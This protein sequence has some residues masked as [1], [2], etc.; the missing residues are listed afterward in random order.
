[1][2]GEIF[3]DWLHLVVSVAAGDLAIAAGHLCPTIE[4]DFWMICY[5]VL[6]QAAAAVALFSR[7]IFYHAPKIS[8]RSTTP[9]CYVKIKGNKERRNQS[10]S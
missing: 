8:K 2:D 6:C 10:D 7:S 1:M 4:Y 5:A 9:L 3:L